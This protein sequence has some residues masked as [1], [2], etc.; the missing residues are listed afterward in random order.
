MRIDIDSIRDRTST[1]R[2]YVDNAE[3]EARRI[4]LEKYASYRLQSEALSSLRTLA[5]DLTVVV[6]SAAW[7]KDCREAIPVLLRLE[8]EAGLNI[9]VFGTIKTAPLNP[10]RRWAIPPSPPEMEAWGV[11]HIPWIVIID[12]SGEQLGTIV[13]RPKVKQTIEEEI[14]HIVAK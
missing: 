9:R 8:E 6:F 4:M 5:S 13:E 7:C 1:V 3:A 14:L 10:N 11:T 2:E 12:K